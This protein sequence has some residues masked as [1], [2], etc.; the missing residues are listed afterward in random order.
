MTPFLPSEESL[1]FDN[2]LA[3][4]DP[5][6]VPSSDGVDGGPDEEKKMS[7]EGNAFEESS[8]SP[9][10]PDQSKNQPTDTHSQVTIVQS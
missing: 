5:S 10:L 2:D 6:N 8:K 1:F 9:E 3:A 4:E 7:N